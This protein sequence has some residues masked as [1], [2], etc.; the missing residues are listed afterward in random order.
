[1]LQWN[2]NPYRNLF[3]IP[4]GSYSGYQ[5]LPESDEN[6]LDVN[7]QQ[8]TK[9]SI[10]NYDYSQIAFYPDITK[11]ARESLHSF[12]KK[13]LVTHAEKL[14][15][16]IRDHISTFE[17]ANL[18]PEILAFERED[19]SI[20]L[21]WIFEK[22]RLGFSFEIEDNESS[23]YLVSNESSGNHRASGTLLASKFTSLSQF[24]L[25][26]VKYNFTFDL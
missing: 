22:F 24:L 16:I 23:W 2:Q 3:Y 4:T 12:D 26:F 8:E 1:M 20:L 11:I 21:E 5:T 9:G 6:I 7:I 18:L 17:N 14:L 10:D 25:E 15:L 13:K 19:K